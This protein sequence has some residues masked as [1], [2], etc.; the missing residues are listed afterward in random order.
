MKED[1]RSQRRNFAF[2]ETKP[3]KI[4]PCSGL[5]LLPSVI[6]VPCSNNWA[7]K[8]TRSRLSKWFVIKPSRCVY[9]C[10]DLLSFISSPCSSYIWFPYIHCLIVTLLRVYDEP[11]QWPG[12]SWLVGLI[13]RALHRY[14]TGKGSN[15]ERAWFFSCFLFATAKVASITALTFFHLGQNI[16]KSPKERHKRKT[17]LR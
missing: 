12:P 16:V 2:A 17:K 1:H 6:P 11:T 9:N 4:Q 3:E 10:D 7:N 13:G 8:P 14:C 5:Q 15:P